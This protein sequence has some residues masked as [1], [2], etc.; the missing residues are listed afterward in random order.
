MFVYFFFD[1][2]EFQNAELE[3]EEVRDR[4]RIIFELYEDENESVMKVKKEFLDFETEFLERHRFSEEEI[5]T[6]CTLCDRKFDDAQR[7]SSRLD[8]GIRHKGVMIFMA[9]VWCVIKAFVRGVA[10]AD[11][12]VISSTR[13]RSRVDDSTFMLAKRRRISLS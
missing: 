10:V 8:W 1:T 3:C 11:A 6:I 7:E 13:K 5:E 2:D 9:A 12:E 4:V